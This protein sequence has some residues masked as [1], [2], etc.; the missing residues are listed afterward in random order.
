MNSWFS[1]VVFVFGLASSARTD[2]DTLRPLDSDARET[3]ARLLARS[4]TARALVTEL[5][6]SDLI[7]HIQSVPMVT[8]G[9]AGMTRFAAARGGYR[10]VRI[11]ILQTLQADERAAILGH[12]LQHACEIARSTASDVDAVRALFQSIGHAVAGARDTFETQAASAVSVDVWMELH[13]TTSARRRST[14]R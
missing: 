7:V 10:Y 1:I 12:E 5:E 6:Q 14:Q 4:P 2:D 3:L 13:G 11:T 9:I 8:T